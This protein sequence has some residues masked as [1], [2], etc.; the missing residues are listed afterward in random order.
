M[1][2]NNS[3]KN[4]FVSILGQ[5]ILIF[6]GFVSRKVFLDSLG[7]EYLGINGLLTNV[8]SLLA[9]VE[10]GIGASIVFF[11]YKPLAEKDTPKIIALVQLYK[12]AYIIIV[13]I[14][15][16]LSIGLYPF[17]EKLININE[18][19]LSFSIIYFLFVAKNIIYY[20]NAHRV[21]LINADQKEYILARI[22]IIFQ[23]ITTVAKILVLIET[24][25]FI[26]YLTIELIIYIIQTVYNG[27][28]VE[29]K[30]SY[31]KT[32]VKYSINK[33][34]KAG[35]IKN[36]KALFL[37][38]IGG[39]VL[40]GTDNILISAFIGI[41]TVGIYSNY[42]MIIGQ[43]NSLLSPIL[44]GIGASVG[45]LIAT[46]NTEK[47]YAVFKTVYLVNFWVYSI[48]TIFLFNLL[49]PFINWWLG[50]GLLLDKYILI[51]LLINFYLTGM[52]SSIFTF[53]AKGGIFVQDKYIPLIGAF[54][55]LILSIVFVRIFGLF[56]IFLGTTISTLSVFWIGPRL[57]YR[58][59]FNKHVTPYFIKYIY[60]FL[61]TIIMCYITNYICS[62]LLTENT[63][64]TLVLRG[65]VCLF[66]AN[67]FY[68]IIF[69]RSEEF[70]YIKD[71]F[72]SNL[73]SIKKKF[74]S[75]R[76]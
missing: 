12:K 44:N 17:L 5:L 49:E 30:Y 45:N 55:N 72:L 18:I 51:I 32:N 76:C 10:S 65:T 13:I 31:L 75:V 19:D 28:V 34:E 11:L 27:M 60:Y 1:R 16:I 66:I 63:L 6:L 47:R 73:S 54:I 41:A 15:T 4:I 36:I 61:L 58:N 26:F 37:H 67:S 14:I 24:Q 53:K 9:L 8:I 3:L 25:N 21:A 50:K 70:I 40:L 56:G 43:L 64:L 57:V 69:Y 35:L 7:I 29:R 46:E 62:N 20:L 39:F 68:L 2:I 52:R 74:K 71:I 59:I 38:N 42:T 23:V 33:E 48:S 22:N